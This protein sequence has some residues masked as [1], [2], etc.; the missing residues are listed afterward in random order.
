MRINVGCVLNLLI[1][2]HLVTAAAAADETVDKARNATG[3]ANDGKAVEVADAEILAMN[4]EL[5]TELEGQLKAL[6]AIVDTDADAVGKY[7]R[8]GDL[9]MFLGKFAE[10]EADYKK[11]SAL[12]PDLDA[13]H[14]RLGIAMYFAQHPRDAAAQFDEY[15]SFDNVDREN[16]IWRYLSHRAAFGKEKAREQL[17]KYEKDD[18]PPFREVYQLFE[19]TMTADQVLQSIS[20]DLPESSRQSRLFYA[21]L[22]VGLNDAVEDK[23]D[24]ALRA[25]REAVKN[26]WPR[27]AGF[28]PDYMWH[29][30]RLEYLRLK[31]AAK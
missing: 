3:D 27:E 29:V 9:H 20:P 22:Y 7:S 21:Q 5:T 28:G 6:P 13:S 25:L 16:G 10:A 18:R 12:N 2:S 23:P 24:S 1:L 30:G 15:H 11:M 17:L 4:K 14:W 31:T 19:G 26:D 8:R